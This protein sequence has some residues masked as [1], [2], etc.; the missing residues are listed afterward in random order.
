MGDLNRVWTPCKICSKYYDFTCEGINN[1]KKCKKLK[2]DNSFR[3]FLVK[4]HYEVINLRSYDL[5]KIY[6][7]DNDFPQPRLT[8][9]YDLRNKS[10][11]E[12]EE[13]L[14]Y[15][16]DFIHTFILSIDDDVRDFIYNN[17]YIMGHYNI[18]MVVDNNIKKSLKYRLDRRFDFITYEFLEKDSIL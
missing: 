9:T 2:L 18:Q 11:K 16:M 14:K 3:N 12:I 4:N 1:V 6:F 5:D 8:D 13:T 17:D 15:G 7:I 10:L